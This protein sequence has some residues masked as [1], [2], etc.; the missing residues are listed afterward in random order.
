METLQ[1]VKQYVCGDAMHIKGRLVARLYGI[2]EIVAAMFTLRKFP[3]EMEDATM[4]AGYFQ[5]VCK[6]CDFQ[7]GEVDLLSQTLTLLTEYYI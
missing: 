2:K 4:L 5:K 7:T 3:E 1:N 6:M